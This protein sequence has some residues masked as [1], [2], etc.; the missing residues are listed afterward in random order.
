MKTY[1]NVNEL[2][3][4]AKGLRNALKSLVESITAPTTKGEFRGLPE[5]LD[6]AQQILD[7]TK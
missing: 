3:T 1:A 6:Q 4:D 7:R 2:L 5:R